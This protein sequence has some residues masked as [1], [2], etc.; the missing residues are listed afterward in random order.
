MEPTQNTRTMTIPTARPKSTA[1]RPLLWFPTTDSF[2]PIPKGLFTIGKSPECTICLH[3]HTVSRFHG[4]GEYSRGQLHLNDTQ[5]RNGMFFRGQ[6]KQKFSLGVEEIALLGTMP[7]VMVA[8]HTKPTRRGRIL[9][10]DAAFTALLDDMTIMAKQ[11]IAI[12]ITGETGSGKEL[13]ARLIHDSSHRQS[14]AYFA[15]NCGAI[16]KDL[17]ESELFGH[18]RGAFSGASQRR[19]GILAQANGG[20]LFLDEIG[21]LRPQ[22]Q[23]SLLRFLETGSYRSVGSDSHR[24]ADVRIIAATHKN[25]RLLARQGMF[26]KDLLYRLSQLTFT[27]PPLRNRVIDIPLLLE[28]FGAPSPPE[29]ILTELLSLPF[30][31]NVRELMSLARI[32]QT[33]GWEKTKEQY[34]NQLETLESSSFNMPTVGLFHS[35]QRQALTDALAKTSGNI[36]AAARILGMPRTTLMHKMKREGL[37]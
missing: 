13:A 19:E 34:A 27:V 5:S 6:R 12:L 2:V 36:S 7:M 10:R 37:R 24:R 35:I 22:H 28:Q 23:S 32:A 17:V 25:L 20:T 15:V 18:E 4:T 26:R 33:F 31:G 14:G 16:P 21:E 29:N 8:N 30:E 11:E 3:H 1:G 9:T